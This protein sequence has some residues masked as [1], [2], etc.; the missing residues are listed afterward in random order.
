MTPRQRD[1]QSASVICNIV[2]QLDT[3]SARTGLTVRELVTRARDGH[4]IVTTDM[5]GHDYTP[6]DPH[7]RTVEHTVT[8]SLPDLRLWD[9]AKE[10][11][12]L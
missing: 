3:A 2:S 5:H 7:S 1:Y 9:K 8:V 10:N 6:F 4:K 11:L 12:G